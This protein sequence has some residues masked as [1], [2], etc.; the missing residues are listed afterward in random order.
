MSKLSLAALNSREELTATGL[1]QHPRSQRTVIVT[2][3]NADGE[4]IEAMA[5]IPKHFEGEDPL[6]LDDSNRLLSNWEVKNDWV[7]PVGGGEGLTLG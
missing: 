2:F 4:E 5:S 1:R 7:L 3:V 6:F